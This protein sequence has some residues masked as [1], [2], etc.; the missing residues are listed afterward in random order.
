MSVVLEVRDLMKKYGSKQALGKVSFTVKEGGCFG[1]LGP[2][3]AGKSTTMKIIAGV[4]EVDG[5]TA[6]VFGKDIRKAGDSIRSQVGY[7]PQDL[8]LYETLS[9]ESNLQFFGEM[10]KVRGAELSKRIA[11][12]LEIVGLSDRAKDAVKSFSGG[13]KRR[14]NIAAALLHKPRLVIM[15]EPTVGID[16]QS[17]HH[18]FEMIRQLKREGVTIIYSTHYMEEVESLC[19]DIAIIDHGQVAAQ[20]S[21]DHLLTQYAIKAVYLEVDR[22]MTEAAGWP[23]IGKVSSYGKGWMLEANDPVA[24]LG[25]VSS[26]LQQKG[27][28]VQA[29]EIMRPSLES[30]FLTLT[31]TTL[32]D[33]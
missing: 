24:A 6:H 11:E 3:G 20:G 9:A 29:L 7:I 10:Y 18:I 30:V 5:G 14:I 27:G 15:D 28:A 4:T 33:E 16:P 12:V 1:L 2:N 22:D 31:G 23:G 13:M 25:Q 21:L 8:T 19:D 17:R 32:R 26:F